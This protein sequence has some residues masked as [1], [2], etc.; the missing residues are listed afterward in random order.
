LTDLAGRR[1]H[2]KRNHLNQFLRKY[3]WEYLPMT[4]ELARECLELNTEWFNLHSTPDHPLSDEDHAMKELL[5]NFEVL[6]VTGA[7]LKV[8]SK[9]EALAIG[10]A[11]NHNTAVIH[12]EKANTV[13]DGAYTAINQKFAAAELS[14]FE[15]IN[16]EEDMGIAGLRQAKLSYHPIQLVEKYV[17]SP[18]D[19]QE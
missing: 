9:I 7:V 13:I 19:D 5:E 4:P 12:I 16:R 8:D 17:I 6:S 1:Y 2:G 18:N 3:Q 11:L 14:G 10:E 15:F